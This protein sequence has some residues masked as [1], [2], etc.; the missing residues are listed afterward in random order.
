M[1]ASFNTVLRSWLSEILT[2]VEQSAKNKQRHKKVMI[3]SEDASTA[4]KKVTDVT[5]TH[6]QN[7]YPGANKES[8]VSEIIGRNG[9]DV[10]RYCI[11]S[12]TRQELMLQQRIQLWFK[13]PAAGQELEYQSM[14]AAFRHCTDSKEQF[15]SFL[16]REQWHHFNKL[17]DTPDDLPKFESELFDFARKRHLPEYMWSVIEETDTTKLWEI[18]E[19]VQDSALYD[20]LKAASKNTP[21]ARKAMK[22]FLNNRIAATGADLTVELQAELQHFF[23]EVGLDTLNGADKCTLTLFYNIKKA[24]VLMNTTTPLQKPV[25]I[26]KLR[27]LPGLDR[28]RALPEYKALVRTERAK[29]A[30]HRAVRMYTAG[31]AMFTKGQQ[32][33][34]PRL[35]LK[36]YNLIYNIKNEE[37]YKGKGGIQEHCPL[38]KD[39]SPEEEQTENPCNQF[40]DKTSAASAI[41]LMYIELLDYCLNPSPPV[42]RRSDMKV[43]ALYRNKEPYDLLDYGDWTLEKKTAYAR[44]YQQFLLDYMNVG[45]TMQGAVG[46]HGLPLLNLDSWGKGELVANP[47]RVREDTFLYKHFGNFRLVPNRLGIGKH[48]RDIWMKHTIKY[49]YDPNYAEAFVMQDQDVHLLRPIFDI[50]GDVKLYFESTIADASKA[51]ARRRWIDKTHT[52][53]TFIQKIMNEDK[54]EMPQ[55]ESHEFKLGR[56]AAAAKEIHDH[57]GKVPADDFKSD[58][59]LYLPSEGIYGI[60][61]NPTAWDNWDKPI[62]VPHYYCEPPPPMTNPILRMGRDL[63]IQRHPLHF[64]NVNTME[65]KEEWI[66]EVKEVPVESKLFPHVPTSTQVIHPNESYWDL[67]RA[68]RFLLK[69]VSMLNEAIRRAPAHEQLST[70]L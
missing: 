4:N 68:L 34:D 56:M 46:V 45:F 20:K 25:D 65:L 31:L 30:A 42:M 70:V 66:R 21:T 11:S 29:L 61:Q 13:P 54:F 40:N 19:L 24:L 60:K 15:E 9:E 27:L 36:G 37:Y 6:N 63:A 69:D 41:L 33:N 26:K 53:D 62:T 10:N 57:L 3:D 48:A 22:Q 1:S 32:F 43:R 28:E 38:F 58:W 5:H 59:Q 18:I 47:F 52:M 55:E 2:T 39:G 14:V 12:A 7:I 49:D 16:Q 51:C 17:L 67:R 35:V 64:T 23:P 8:I 50:H 44:E